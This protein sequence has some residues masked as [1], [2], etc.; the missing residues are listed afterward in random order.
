MFP[1]ILLANNQQTFDTFIEE[2]KEKHHFSGIQTQE[3]LPEKT[4]IT[5]NQI[6]ELKKELYITTAKP[7]LIIFHSFDSA[8]LEA[9]NALLK[10]LEE[11]NTKNQ[12]IMLAS[13]VGNI[14]P[15]II[16]RSR[17]LDLEENKTVHDEKT[18][19]TIDT[20]LN[21]PSITY[22]S[23]EIFSVATKEDASFILKI[24]IERLRKAM[25]THINNAEIIK[26][27]FDLLY[28]LEHN[29]LSAQLTIDNW[30]ILVVK[31]SQK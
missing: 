25:I 14:L 27:T 22:L 30:I 13:Q 4:T 17:V 2:F 12:F 16:S 28:K 15:T 19:Q 7:R 6:R 21:E 5:I 24:C 10:V 11:L 3:M 20:F 23:H 9:Q 18:I 29:N 31:A 26:P 1:L 8:T